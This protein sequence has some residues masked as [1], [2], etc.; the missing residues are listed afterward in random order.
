MCV[1]E[2]NYCRAK[3]NE[4]S[5]E[6]KV[7]HIYRE[8]NRAADWLANLGASHASRLIILSNIPVELSRILEEDIRGVALPRLAPP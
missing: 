6:V 5:W 1:H 8:G 7:S 4:D 3:I 2:L